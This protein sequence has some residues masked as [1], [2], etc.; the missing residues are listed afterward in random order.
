[1]E[2]PLGLEPRTPCLKG[3]CSNQL[4]YGPIAAV[5]QYSILGVICLVLLAAMFGRF[6]NQ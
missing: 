4:S 2:G 1:M 3:R 5:S 6:G